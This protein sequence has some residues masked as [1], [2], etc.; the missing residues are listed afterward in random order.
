MVKIDVP[1]RGG[2]YM[3]NF[4]PAIGHEQSGF[5]PAV[6]VSDVSY[7]QKVGMALICPVTSARKG[8][9]FEVY[10]ET[11]TLSGVV[12]TDQIKSMDWHAR[13]LRYADRLP[14]EALVEMQTKLVSLIQS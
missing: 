2:I 8:Y 4:D 14:A 1:V 12:L 6:V 9:P 5:R 10:F 7:N 11:K 13:R 3:A